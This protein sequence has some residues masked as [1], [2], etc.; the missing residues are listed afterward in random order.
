MYQRVSDRWKGGEGVI[1]EEK[2]A[3]EDGSKSKVGLKSKSSSNSRR[4]TGRG[5]QRVL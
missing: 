4:D 5:N 1:S 2:L 3:D